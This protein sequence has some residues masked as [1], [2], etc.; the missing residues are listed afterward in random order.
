MQAVFD[1]D[2][3]RVRSL[4]GLVATSKDAVVKDDPVK[5]LPGQHQRQ[6]CPAFVGTQIRWRRV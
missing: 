6:P 1:Q 4:Q 3:Q 5:E 2:P